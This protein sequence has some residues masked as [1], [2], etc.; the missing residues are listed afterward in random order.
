MTDDEI[1]EWSRSKI[2]A[3]PLSPE[4][5]VDLVV[6]AW[7]TSEIQTFATVRIEFSSPLNAIT[8]MADMISSEAF[9]AFDE[10]R[11]REYSHNISQMARHLWEVLN[12]LLAERRKRAV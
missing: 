7:R 3:T 12:S 5:T 8:G 1:R 6:E 4:A 10:P 2:A 11:Y 9:G